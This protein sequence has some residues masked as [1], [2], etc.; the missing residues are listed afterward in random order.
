MS[1]VEK[2]KSF[3]EI[4]ETFLKQLSPIIGTT[5]HFYFQKLVKANAVMPIQQFLLEVLPFKEKIMNKDE[6]YF[7][8]IESNA[9]DKI[10]GDEQVLTEILRLKDIYTGLDKQSQ[11][12][13]WNYFQALIILSE[14]YQSC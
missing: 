8:Q 3:N 9:E 2:I 11:S 12:E 5:Y 4:L 6:S 10:G 7:Y 13:V 1:K 14:E